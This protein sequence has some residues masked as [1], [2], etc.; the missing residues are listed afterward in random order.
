M[1]PEHYFQV[2]CCPKCRS[3]FDTSDVNNEELICPSCKSRYPV[4]EDIPVLLPLL[5][6]DI[7]QIVKRFYDSEWKRDENGFLKAKVKHE[8]LSN[9]GQLYIERNE[10]RFVSLFSQEQD[11]DQTFFLDIGSGA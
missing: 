8:D 10:T 1:I 5:E 7:S 4:V 2:I 11:G 9:L 3:K 6:D